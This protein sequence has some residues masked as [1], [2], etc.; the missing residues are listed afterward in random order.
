MPDA[1]PATSVLC[2][3]AQS[4]CTRIFHKSHLGWKFTGKMLNANPAT[5]V[6]CEPAHSKDASTCH[7]SRFV[8]KLTGTVPYANRHLFCA[9]LRRRFRPYANPACAVEMHM[10]ISQ[11]PFCME[12]Y[13]E[14]AK[15][16]I[17]GPRFVRACAIKMHMD[18]S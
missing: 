17:R 13:R 8:W 3:P 18:I 11:E 4:K 16:L 2:K 10:D 14:N 7:K 1:T 15:P 6:L 12:I 5:P 9:S